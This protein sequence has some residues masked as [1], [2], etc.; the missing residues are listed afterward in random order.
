[1]KKIVYRGENN[2]DREENSNACV[3]W[4]DPGLS[5]TIQSM[6]EDNDIAKIMERYQQTGQ[7]P[8][9]RPLMYGDFDDVV[10]FRS[11]QDRFRAAQNAFDELPA[12]VRD[13]FANDPQRYLEFCSDPEN[14]PEMRKLGI[15]V[16]AAASP[17]APQAAIST[18]PA[19]RVATPPG[20]PPGG[21]PAA[22]PPGGPISST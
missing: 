2:F 9:A 10:D 8:E 7:L 21:A 15:A 18:P 22:P 6:A 1:M 14:L 12:K 13:R 17:E 16:P 11:C 19:S 3:A 20:A 4:V 5:L